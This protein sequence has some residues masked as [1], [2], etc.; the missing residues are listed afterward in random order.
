MGA[1]Q[2]SD[3]KPTAKSLPTE[4]AIKGMTCSNCARHVTEAIQSV[5]EVASASVQLDA[6]RAT[7]RW[8]GVPDVPAVM[9][10]VKEAGYGRGSH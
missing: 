2:T 7:V 6:G 5:P 10:A 1:V 9:E 4:L 3:L 8:N